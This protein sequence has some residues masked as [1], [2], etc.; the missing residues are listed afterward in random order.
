L[1]DAAAAEKDGNGIDT[2]GLIDFGLS[3]GAV[4]V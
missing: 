2:E 4:V 1:I 3:G